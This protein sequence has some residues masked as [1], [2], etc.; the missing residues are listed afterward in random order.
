MRSPNHYYYTGGSSLF[1]VFRLGIRLAIF[2]VAPLVLLSLGRT[3]GLFPRLKTPSKNPARTRNTGGVHW[4][5]IGRFYRPLCD[6]TNKTG[7]RTKTGGRLPLYHSV[8]GAASY[9]L[10][11]FIETGAGVIPCFAKT[12]LAERLNSTLPPAISRCNRP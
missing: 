11:R 3:E 1:K 2:V 10:A 12:A 8:G 9:G 7:H 4:E 6:L 5:Y